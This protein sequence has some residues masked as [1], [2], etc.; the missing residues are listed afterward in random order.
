MLKIKFNDY[1]FDIPIYYEQRIILNQSQSFGKNYQAIPI[2]SFYFLDYIKCQTYEYGKNIYNKVID[3]FKY[4][5]KDLMKNIIEISKNQ[6]KLYQ[7]LEHDF[8]TNSVFI[9]TDLQIDRSHTESTN[10]I[11]KGQLC[12]LKDWD[13][14]ADQSYHHYHDN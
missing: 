7:T 3:V 5:I 14:L 8:D 11:I 4:G 1:T 13:E 12:Y 10:I 6:E 2:T 9:I